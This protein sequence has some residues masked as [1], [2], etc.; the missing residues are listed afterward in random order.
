M[1]EIFESGHQYR[2][3]VFVLFN[4]RFTVKISQKLRYGKTDAEE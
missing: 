3:E 1:H 2:S 4:L